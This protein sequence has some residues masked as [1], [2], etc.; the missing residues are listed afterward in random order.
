VQRLKAYEQENVRLQRLLGEQALEVVVMQ[1]VP[2]K[3]HVFATAN[4]GSDDSGVRHLLAWYGNVSVGSMTPTNVANCAM[5]QHYG[6]QN[7]NE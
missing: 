2:A 5:L 6:W 1:D 7:D 3:T 4:N